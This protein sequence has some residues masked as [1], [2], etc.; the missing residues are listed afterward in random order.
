MSIFSGLFKS[1]DKPKNY[2]S[3]SGF[4]FFFGHTA[5]GKDVN[6]RTAL[7]VTTVYACVRCL[8]EAIGG[9]PLHVYKYN[10]DGSKQ[11]IPEHFLYKLL[12]D[13]PNSEMTSFVWRETLMS[14]LLIY[15]NAFSQILRDGRGQVV[16]LYP[17]LPSRMDV[18]R[19]ENGSIVYTYH[20][21]K[22]SVRLTKWSVLHIPALGFDGLVGY[23]PIAMAKNTI[24]TAL[25]VEEY[26]SK[27]FANG[28]TPGGV[29]EFPGPVKDVNRV[30]ET[31]NAGY[32]GTENAHR[33]AVLEE[34]A[35]FVPMSIPPEQ[36]QFLETRKFTTNEICRLFKVPPHLVGDLE[37]ATFSNIE[38]QS[39]DFVT[40][41][42][43]P[44]VARWEQS[45]QQALILP[46][47]QGKIFIKFNVDGLLRGDYAS[48][49]QGYATARQNGWLSANDIRELEDMNAI[50]KEQGGD[51]Y[52]VNG[53]MI[54]ILSAKKSET[55]GENAETKVL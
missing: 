41:S 33:T 4:R 44:W 30:K 16:G 7:S 29:L 45:L 5:A 36:A 51:E 12:H 52:L 32:Q 35:H 53:S 50:P 22:G 24:G 20:S 13:A 39:I 21:D 14:H 42:V 28:A 31:W 47:E 26:G 3:D 23:S 37:H 8:A 25:A 15:G 10:D 11:R 40:H 27:F 1:R 46:S 19:D 18:D 17:L 48:R 43:R 55:G 34:G 49:M 2:Y 6:E 54:P 9:L 38:H